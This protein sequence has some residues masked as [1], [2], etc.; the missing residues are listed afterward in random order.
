M[1]AKIMTWDE[2]R[3]VCRE[4]AANWHQNGNTIDDLGTADILN[5]YPDDYFCDNTD[6]WCDDLSHA[7]TPVEFVAQTLEYLAEMTEEA[8]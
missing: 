1:M 6:D 8:E 2:F 5:E 4:D 3:E 7:F